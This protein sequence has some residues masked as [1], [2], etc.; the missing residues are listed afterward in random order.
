MMKDDIDLIKS[1]ITK[2]KKKSI[3]DYIRDPLYISS[4]NYIL[5]NIF[6]AGCGFFFWVMA[7]RFYSVEDVGLSTALISSIGLITLF[8]KVGF[9]FSIIRYFPTCDKSK[10]INTSITITAIISLLI[11]IVYVILV[12]IISQP[13]SFIKQPIYSITFI[14]IGSTEAVSLIA[15][16][17]LIASRKSGCYLLQNLFLALRIM[18]LIFIAPLGALGIL[19]SIGISFLAALIFALF[20]LEKKVTSI[21]PKID[22]DFVL[23]SLKFTSWNYL[24]N[25]LFAAPTLILPIMVLNT[26]GE[27]EAAKYYIA[28]AIGNLALIIPSA[29]GVSVFV[30]GS[31][32]KALKSSATRAGIAN[33]I[34]LLPGVLVLYLFGDHLLGLLKSE[35]MSAFDLLKILALS[36]F[37]V[38]IYYLFTPI[39][40]VRMKVESI[41]MI[42]SL[43]LIGLL[44]LSYIL[45]PQY[46]IIGLG[47]AWFIIYTILTAVIIITIVREKWI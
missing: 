44:G 16:R 34:I 35:Y 14:L 18:L 19:G 38:S 10:V 17:A 5:S 24:A 6:N 47:Y 23:E 20:V 21:R 2:F 45:M 46:G 1:V 33:F 30:E 13:L 26:L 32:G 39:Q 28:F 11:G 4:F 29:L 3:F 41:V 25:I 22:K 43:R 31:H 40:N 37:L 42:N 15:G 12:D 7:A 9:E 8:S 36:S 27:A